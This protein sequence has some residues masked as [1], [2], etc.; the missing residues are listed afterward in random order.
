MMGLKYIIF[1][2]D[3]TIADT[4]ELGL[5]IFNSIAPE[6]DCAPIKEEDWFML[7]TMKP[8]ELIKEYGISNIKL[9][10]ILF[11]VRKEMKA[12]ANELKPVKNIAGSLMEIKNSGLRMGILTSN[13][14]NNVEMFLNNNQLSNLIDFIYSG[15]SFFGK[16]RVLRRLFDHENIPKE[17]VIYV[18]D[19]TRD[20]EASRRAG[21]PVIAV[22]WGFHN[23][24]ILASLKPDQIAETPEDL[25]DCIRKIL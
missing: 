23:R 20:I 19:E 5:D 16:D 17:N 10:L 12:H 24:D 1:D 4:I 22:S 2:F 25:Y 13:S 8:Q 11:R 18:G 6:Y 3:G 14:R 7:R 9:T 15:K 21:I